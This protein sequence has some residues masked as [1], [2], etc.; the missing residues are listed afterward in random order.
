MAITRWD[1]FRDL[2]DLHKSFFG[3]MRN[4]SVPVSDVFVK[5]NQLTVRAQL[6]DFDED[7]VTVQVN[8]GMLE[9]RAEHSEKNEEGE[10]DKK[11][12]LRESS[13]S[14]YRS[15]ALPANAEEGKIA[16]DLK[17]GV[18]TVSVPLTPKPEPKKIAIKK[19]SK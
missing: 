4:L 12:V 6:P 5:D 16:A 15:I 13:S 17:R 9:I 3:S 11:Y 19:S 10:K 8:D 14:F 18:L 7:E 2:E 1:P